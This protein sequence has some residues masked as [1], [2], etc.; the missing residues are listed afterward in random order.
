LRESQIQNL[1]KIDENFDDASTVYNFYTIDVNG[2]PGGQ[3]KCLKNWSALADD[4]RTF[5]LM[6]DG[7]EAIFQQLT[8]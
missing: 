2:K 6:R 3:F 8:A 7:S 5:L 4:F 1:G